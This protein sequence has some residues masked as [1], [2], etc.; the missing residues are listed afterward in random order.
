VE[1]S[2]QHVMCVVEVNRLTLVEGQPLMVVG[3]VAT[4]NGMCVLKTGLG[5]C[6]GILLF[7]FLGASQ[8]IAPDA[9]QP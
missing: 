2:E 4:A 8:D 6:Q 1:D 5:I 3:Y 7:L 9:P